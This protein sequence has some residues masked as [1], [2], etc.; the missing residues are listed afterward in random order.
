MSSALVLMDKIFPGEVKSSG[1]YIQI[2]IVL[3]AIRG[4]AVTNTVIDDY[5]SRFDFLITLKPTP[6]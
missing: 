3:D 4:I 6:W 2:R 5:T 1:N